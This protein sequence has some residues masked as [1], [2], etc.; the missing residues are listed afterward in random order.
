MVMIER[1]PWLRPDHP[2]AQ[3]A[4]FVLV[5]ATM[6]CLAYVVSAIGY[7]AVSPMFSSGGAEGWV[8]FGVSLVVA[9]VVFALHPFYRWQAT[10]N[11]WF[12]LV[13]SLAIPLALFCLWFGAT[14]R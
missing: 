13:A 8:F 2:V 4:V 11:R 5:Q 12:L 7:L 1:P 9:A 10:G 3:I 6:T 14:T